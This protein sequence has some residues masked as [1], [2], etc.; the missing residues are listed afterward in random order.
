MLLCPCG[1]G[2]VTQQLYHPW[3]L[4]WQRFLPSPPPYTTL[5]STC[6][7][8]PTS[9]S[10][11]V[12]IWPCAERH[13]VAR[14]RELA[15]SLIT[16]KYA[17][18]QGFPMGC[19]RATGPADT[20]LALKLSLVQERTRPTAAPSRLPGYLKDLCRMRW[21]SVSSPTSCRATSSRQTNTPG[22]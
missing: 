16:K 11:C 22:Q 3:L 5:L 19:Q 8:S 10:L 6:S 21:P 17:T 7:S 2:L 9:A 13:S 1:Q 15:G 20:A 12:A 4:L 14:R 18:L